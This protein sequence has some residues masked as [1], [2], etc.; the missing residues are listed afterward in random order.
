MD[1]TSTIPRDHRGRIIS[2]RCPDPNCGGTLVPDGDPGHWR[3]NGLTHDDDD[4][5]PLV[6]CGITHNDGKPFDP[7]PYREDPCS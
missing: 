3:C 2:T 6:A 4:R 7:T 1:V 5:A